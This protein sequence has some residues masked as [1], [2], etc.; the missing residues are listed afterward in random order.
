MVLDELEKVA[1]LRLSLANAS[2]V[3]LVKISVVAKLPQFDDCFLTLMSHLII[4]MIY[5]VGKF[6]RLI[7]S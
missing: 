1:H 4:F 2:D 7:N 6:H 5:I 3:A